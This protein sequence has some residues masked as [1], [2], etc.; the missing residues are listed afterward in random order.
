MTCPVVIR[1]STVTGPPGIGLP[2]G[3]ADAGK[4]VQKDG[5]N[6][7]QYRLVTLDQVSVQSVAGR[8]G[9]V[10][11][12]KADV[13]LNNV[14]NTGDLAKPIS[15]ATQTAL[16][17][18]TSPAEA[19]AAAP[20]QS[21]AG[22]TGAVVLTVADV[23]G[24][25]SSSALS[26]G[27]AGKADLIGGLVPSTQLPGFVDDVLEFATFAGFPVTGETGK[28]YVSLATNRIWRWSGSIYVEVVSSPGSTDAVTEGSVNLYFTTARGEAAAASW[29]AASAAKTKLDGIAAG[30]TANSSDATLLARGN[31]TGTQAFS[32]ITGTPTTLSGYGI[33]DGFT[34]AD[35]RATP[36]T[37]FTSGAGTVAATDTILQAIQKLDGNDAAKLPITFT[38]STIT[39][40]STVDLDMAA[41]AGQ[42]CTISLT[43]NLELTALNRAAGR[44]VTLRLLCDA[45]TR[46]LTF[47]AAWVFLG[48]KPSS[49]AASKAAVLSLTFFGAN[50]ADCVAAYGVQE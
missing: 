6:A 30:A 20:V 16:D 3:T 13:G 47:P 11:L 12:V 1:V 34:Q 18:K 31:H 33:T 46:T 43:G 27:L 14:D 45:T 35:V 41:L 28:L 25:A 36:I 21:V 38:P 8:T 4:F 50:N 23:S 44:Q 5:A 22:R 7:Y 17:L 40:A 32:T 15:T 37:G 49:L 24:A 39:Y 48:T 29:W 26:S 2:A 10:T 19:A 9:A 42:Y